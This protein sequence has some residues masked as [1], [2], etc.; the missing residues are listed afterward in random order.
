MIKI[1]QGEFFDGQIK[2]KGDMYY[3]R[4]VV[5]DEKQ[6]KPN[7]KVLDKKKTLDSKKVKYSR[8][9]LYESNYDFLEKIGTGGGNKLEISESRLEGL[10]SIAPTYTDFTELEEASHS[11][12]KK[13][14]Y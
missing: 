2:G 3:F 12:S 5:V 1:Y 14:S 11:S 4:K 6:K 9:S 7:K 8:V 13:Y 10:E